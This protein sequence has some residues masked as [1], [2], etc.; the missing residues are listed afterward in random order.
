MSFLNHD[1][2]WNFLCIKVF[3][4]ACF[5][6]EF[7]K[8]GKQI[9]LNC[10]GLPLAIVMT[11]G[12]LL[13]IGESLDEWKGVSE[14]ITSLISTDLDVQ[15]MRVLAL[16]YHHLPH[17]LKPFFLY[18]A[19]FPE[20]ELISVNKLVNLWEA[21]GFSCK[22]YAEQYLPMNLRVAEGFSSK[23]YAEQCLTDLIDRS[24]IFIHH[25][26]F[27]GKIK[28]C[29][30]HDVICELFLREA[31][32]L[33]F[34][35]VIIEDQNSCEQ[36]RHFSRKCRISVQSEQTS[37]VANQLATVHHNKVRSILLFIRNPSNSRIMQELV[38]FKVL[39]IL[40]LASPT[41]DAFPSCVVDLSQLRY[42][43]LTFYSSINDHD[44]NVPPSIARLQ[45]LETFILKFPKYYGRPKI[46]FTL[47]GE[48]FEI[49]Q[50]RNLS[51]DRNNMVTHKYEVNLQNLQ[52]LSAL[53]PL[54][55]DYFTQQVC[56][57]RKFQICANQQDYIK[58]NEMKGLHDLRSFILLQELKFDGI[59]HSVLPPLEAFPENLKKLALTNTCVNLED[60]QILGH[61]LEALKLKFT[62]SSYIGKEWE[63]AEEGFPQLKFLLL[64][65]LNIKY[66]R[67]SSDQFPRL[68]RLFLEECMSMDSI[69]EDFA[70]ITTLQLIDIRMCKESVAN[71]A[72]KIQQDVEDNYYGG[73]IEVHF[74]YIL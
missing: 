46:S 15:C 37:F 11:A 7:E 20:D 52:C 57:V 49:S 36:T 53:N 33:N 12:L 31:R 72:N 62:S 50:L 30:M 51:L 74:R 26:S 40:K 60:L 18:F 27:D 38:R 17:H 22:Q 25:L 64:N 61:K 24:L 23:E 8:V 32:N 55:C 14:N 3:E 73:S 66:W 6:P 58:C 59:P 47:P 13:K 5:P 28:A 10:K 1:E 45:S 63:V 34:V 21:E 19:I 2:S 67:V 4:N 42:L 48:I 16:S 43:A 70:A 54:Y 35:N 56:Y 65:R 71:S 44:I 29:G 9:V 68:K 41:L 39:R 69:P